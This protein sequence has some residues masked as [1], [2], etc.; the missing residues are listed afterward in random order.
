[1][2]AGASFLLNSFQEFDACQFVD[3]LKLFKLA[4]SLG[5]VESLAELPYEMSHAELPPEERLAAG[6]SPQLI[7]LAVGIE[8]V[9]DLKADLQQALM[10]VSQQ[11]QTS[12]K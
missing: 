5:A 4:V 7:R 12:I 1:M 6:I 11:P 8:D 10:V 3:H 9:T 2:A